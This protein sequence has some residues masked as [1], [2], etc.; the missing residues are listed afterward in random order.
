L[1]HPVRVLSIRPVEDEDLEIVDDMAKVTIDVP[2]K[3]PPPV[4]ISDHL[5]EEGNGKIEEVIHT[6]P[7]PYCSTNQ[8]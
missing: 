4:V 1:V 3:S 6:A 7:P 2:S 5:E 8:P